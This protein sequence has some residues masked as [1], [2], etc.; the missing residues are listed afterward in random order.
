MPWS[1]RTYQHPADYPA[2]LA[3]WTDAGPGIHLS[4]TDSPQGIEHKLQRDPELFLVAELD[5]EI[6][7]TV[8]GGYDGRRGL[9]YHLAVEHAWRAQGVGRALMQAVEERL[10]AKGCFKCYLLVAWDDPENVA[11]YEHLGWE[12]MQVSVM[13]KQ[14]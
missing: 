5:G 7:G 13:G 12:A 2:V 14:L 4:P 9:V 8:L 11:F 3:L 10:R 1:L 6:I